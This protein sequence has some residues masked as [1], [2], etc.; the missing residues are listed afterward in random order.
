MG[1]L[2]FSRLL[3]FF[4]EENNTNIFYGWKLLGQNLTDILKIGKLFKNVLAS[5]EEKKPQGVWET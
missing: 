3:S 4:K 1:F 5:G 2:T